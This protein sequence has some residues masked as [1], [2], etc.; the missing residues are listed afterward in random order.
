MDPPMAG[1]AD[2]TFTQDGKWQGACPADMKP[3]DMVMPTGMKMNILD[4]Q[5]A[6]GQH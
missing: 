4:M 3:G 5:K 1:H 6:A 2:S